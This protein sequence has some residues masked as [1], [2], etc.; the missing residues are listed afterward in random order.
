VRTSRVIDIV[1]ER[2]AYQLLRV[3]IDTRKSLK[4]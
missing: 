1:D 4:M 2:L 3:R